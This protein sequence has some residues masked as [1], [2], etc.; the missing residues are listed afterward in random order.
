MEKDFAVALSFDVDGELLWT[1][2]DESYWNRKVLMSQGQYGIKEGVPRI[3]RLLKKYGLKATFFVPG[4]IAD[5]YPQLVQTICEDGHE[6]G[7]H[8]YWHDWPENYQSYDAEEESFVKAIEALEKVTGKKPRGYRSP[9]WEFSDW[10]IDIAKKHGIIYS[11]NMMDSDSIYM[12]EGLV[13]LPVQWTLDDAAY[14]LYSTKLQ[15][16]A[17]QPLSN[18][19]EYWT[20]EFS[21]MYE[22]YQVLKKQ[23]TFI[24]TMHPQIT[25]RP[26]RTGLLENFIQYVLKHPGVRFS[27]MGE[28]ADEYLEGNR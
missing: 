21:Y 20:T 10:T 4:Y 14:F 11:S 15:G 1:A 5:T 28:L 26:A 13:E 2:R 24:L 17:I 9:A 6:I 27:T 18:A 23:N 22:E 16:K 3:L 25:G 19:Y 7:H 8:S 12:N